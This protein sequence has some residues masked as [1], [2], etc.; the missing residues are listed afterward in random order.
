MPTPDNNLRNILEQS[1][2]IDDAIVSEQQEQEG[3][4]P[5]DPEKL[6]TD[7]KIELAEQKI[8]LAAVWGKFSG[9][10]LPTNLD[11]ARLSDEEFRQLLND[12]LM[13][14][15]DKA[16]EEIGFD[17]EADQVSTINQEND[18]QKKTVLQL[19]FINRIIDQTRTID[20]GGK[21]NARSS[22]DKW[23]FYPKKIMT[24]KLINCSGSAL[25][26]GRIL[27]KAGI[28]VENAILYHHE[29]NAVQLA[30][31][32]MYFVDSRR[33]KDNISNLGKKLKT[34]GYFQYSELGNPSFAQTKVWTG[35]KDKLGVETLLNNLHIMK[36]QA[37][38]TDNPDEAAKKLLEGISDIDGLNFDFLA[39]KLYP[40]NSN[41]YQ[42]QEWIDER[43]QTEAKW[44][45]TKPLEESKRKIFG[46]LS[47]TEINI[48]ASELT[49]KENAQKIYDFCSAPE[50]DISILVG[51]SEQAQNYAI[52]TGGVLRGVLED[53]KSQRAGGKEYEFTLTTLRSELGLEK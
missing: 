33:P 8:K 47:P 3:L 25:L 35:P 15:I 1:T 27:E 48:L 53:I 38:R 40:E 6:E 10:E 52:L 23:C 49:K 26:I 14:G 20:E 44:D 19:K 13:A 51:L 28:P 16:I 2:E 41:I 34:F 7:E 36:S 30:D 11:F 21:L 45:I 17:T 5:V 22:Q 32:K 50:A 4:I 29:A 9:A 43:N 24:D 18:P 46:G 37:E 31:G 39:H 12:N 42:S